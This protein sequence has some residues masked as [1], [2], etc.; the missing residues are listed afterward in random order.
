MSIST[1]QTRVVPMHLA[2]FL[3]QLEA[4]SVRAHQLAKALSPEQWQQRPPQGGWC[5]A[6]CLMHLNITSQ[7]YLPRIREAIRR[8]AEEKLLSPGPFRKGFA[9][10]LLCKLLE[11]PYRLRIKTPPAFEPPNIEPAESVMKT[12]ETL[13]DGL[14]A[15]IR[16]SKGLALDRLKFQSPFA[17][18][19]KYSLYSTYCVIPAHQRRHLW[20]AEQVQ[21]RLASGN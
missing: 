17:E 4:A 8:G 15:C 13:Q 1:V 2:E 7:A 11:P 12:W 19:M 9:G 5:V 6:E 20:Q 10:W 3:I 18:E 14:V 21:K 16:E